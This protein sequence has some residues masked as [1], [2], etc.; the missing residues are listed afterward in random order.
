MRCGAASEHHSG[1]IL[2][3]WELAP[4]RLLGMVGVL[5]RVKV[6]QRCWRVSKCPSDLV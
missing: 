6:Y 1:V 3:W 5:I 4:E 2:L